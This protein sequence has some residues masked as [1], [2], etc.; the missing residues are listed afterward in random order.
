MA[1]HSK[2][3]KFCINCMGASMRALDLLAEAS[4]KAAKCGAAH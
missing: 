3:S 4:D 2:S 1:A